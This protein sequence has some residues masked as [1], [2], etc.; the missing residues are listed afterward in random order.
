[1]EREPVPAEPGPATASDAPDESAQAARTGAVQPT[2][3]TTEVRDSD[4]INTHAT[5]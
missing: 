5:G 2:A 4:N 1:M 3:T